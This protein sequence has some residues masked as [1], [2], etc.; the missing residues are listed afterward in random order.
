M[1][2][3]SWYASGMRGFSAAVL[4]SLMVW[5]GLARAQPAN[6]VESRARELLSLGVEESVSVQSLAALGPELT[7]AL[8]TIFA[9][10]SEARHVRLRALSMLSH[11]DDARIT[12]LLVR[13]VHEGVAQGPSTSD[14]LHPS[15]SSL[16]LR[17]AIEGITLRKVPALSGDLS[18]ALEH[19]DAQ[20]RRAAVL[21]LREIANE[22]VERTLSLQL[23][24]ETSP[25]VLA[26]LRD[27]SVRS[28]GPRPIALESATR[29]R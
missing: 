29:P 15:R 21:A 17:K 20:V 1:G 28:Q 19:G 7:P 3:S 9:R 8:L 6:D 14:P 16:V 25:L 18:R 26:V 2:F 10:T 24:R 23:T 27:R 22:K 11:F 5:T 13:L 4:L 12:A